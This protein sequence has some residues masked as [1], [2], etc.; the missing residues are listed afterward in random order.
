MSTLFERCGGFAF[1]SKVVMD[2]YD[3]VLDHDTL[4]AYFADIDMRA[5]VDHQTKFMATVTGGPASYTD[6]A[7]RAV[8]ARLRIDADSFDAMLALLRETLQDHDL[9]DQDVAAVV[10]EF[11]RRRPAI[12]AEAALAR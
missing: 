7:L 8:H 11:R 12:V 2:F 1:L 3:R 6:E 10:G 4:G 5:L 9:A